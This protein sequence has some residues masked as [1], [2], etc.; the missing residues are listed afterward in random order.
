[1][2]A[3]RHTSGFVILVYVGKLK[4]L[5]N[6]AKRAEGKL[7][8]IIYTLFIAILKTLQ[9]RPYLCHETNKLTLKGPWD[10]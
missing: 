9:V 2:E 3:V 7:D 6:S 1:M 10:V 8:Q 5:Q 4:K